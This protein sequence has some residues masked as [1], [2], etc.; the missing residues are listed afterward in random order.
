MMC[1]DK[2]KVLTEGD[3]NRMKSILSKDELRSKMKS[4]LKDLTPREYH[5][6][7]HSLYTNFLGLKLL[8][9]A[10][11]I[12]IYYS[13]RNEANTVHIINYLL[14]AGKTV[15]LPVCTPERD[16]QAVVITDLSQLQPAP[17]GLMEPGPGADLLENSKL[18]LIV[19]PGIAFDEKGHRLGHGAGYYDRFLLKTP[20]AFKLGLAYDFQLLPEIPAESHDIKMNGLLTPTRYLEF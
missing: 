6:L 12:M 3:G 18:E 14:K 13:V 19:I 9:K 7:N 5:D 10:N 11:Y 4:R 8:N 20:N 15:A 2:I 17:F 1:Y 16:L